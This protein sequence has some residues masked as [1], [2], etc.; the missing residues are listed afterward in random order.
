MKIDLKSALLGLL[1]GIGTMF[2]MGAGE[3]SPNEGK[4]QV[5]TGNSIVV[6]LNTETGQAWY[7][8][9]QRSGYM[10]ETG[11]FWDKKPGR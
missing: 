2:A 4:F 5:A 6:I 11:G 1:I 3:S 8:N 7:S 10:G 9:L